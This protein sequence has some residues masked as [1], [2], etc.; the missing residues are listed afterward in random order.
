MSEGQDG[1][2]S[3]GWSNDGCYR[4]NYKED[5]GKSSVH[6]YLIRLANESEKLETDLKNEMVRPN[7]RSGRTTERI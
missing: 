3:P 6:D 2:S 5:T 1:I 4:E 7:R